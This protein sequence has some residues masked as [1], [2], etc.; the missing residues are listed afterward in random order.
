MKY[1]RL[2]EIILAG[3]LSVAPVGCGN[4]K[5]RAYVI[6]EYAEEPAI[7]FFEDTDRNGSYDYV[8]ICRF[9]GGK[10]CA[11]EIAELKGEKKVNDLYVDLERK[12]L[13]K[14]PLVQREN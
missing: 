10:S 7:Y 3:A 5:H 11:G 14:V 6:S 12:T 4:W 2:S 1:Q 8:K 9:E 13:E